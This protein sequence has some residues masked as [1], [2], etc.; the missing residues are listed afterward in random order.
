MD[1]AACDSSC[2]C[3]ILLLLNMSYDLQCIECVHGLGTVTPQ[4][5]IHFLA[6]AICYE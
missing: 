3:Y 2:R 6:H 5:S 4:K 1:A